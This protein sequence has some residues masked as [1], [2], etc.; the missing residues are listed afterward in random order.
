MYTVEV[1]LAA[2]YAFCAK[3]NLRETTREQYSNFIRNHPAGGR[4]PDASARCG[5]TPA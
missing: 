2:W 3:P 5:S 4:E 1:W